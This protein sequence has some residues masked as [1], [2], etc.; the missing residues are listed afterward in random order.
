MQRDLSVLLDRLGDLSVRQG[1]LDEALV[2]HTKRKEI[3]SALAASDPANAAWQRDLS[4]S[5]SRLGELAVAQGDLAGALRYFSE[6]QTI[7]ERLAAS[8]PANAE[9]Q[10]DLSYSCWIIAAKVY[11]PQQRWTEALALM[12]QS[13]VVFNYKG[14]AGVLGGSQA[15]AAI[16]ALEVWGDTRSTRG[17]SLT[18]G[19]TNAYRLEAP[20]SGLALG[21]EHQDVGHAQTRPPCIR[22]DRPGRPSTQ[23]RLGT[24]SH[25]LSFSEAK[26]AG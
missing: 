8:D 11:E 16:K 1:K 7:A 3:F 10:R 18:T 17:T 19:D 25:Q 21:V 13:M 20:L 2:F 4:V 14:G 5:L 22:V 15:E 9:W 26:L 6:R 12:E 24:P 23:R